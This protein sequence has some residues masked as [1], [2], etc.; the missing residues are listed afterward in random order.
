MK[1]VNNDYINDRINEAADIREKE[2]ALI[3]RLHMIEDS[4]VLKSILGQTVWTEIEDKQCTPA[5]LLP[6]PS[7][8]PIFSIGINNFKNAVRKANIALGEFITP[9]HKSNPMAKAP[10]GITSLVDKDVKYED[11]TIQAQL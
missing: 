9:G 8:S 7:D 4:L 10:C 2:M 6:L 11:S 1:T 3:E 5:Y